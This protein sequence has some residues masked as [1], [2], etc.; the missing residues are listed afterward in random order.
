MGSGQGC[1]H[2]TSRGVWLAQVGH[3]G[4]ETRASLDLY[5]N[6][7]YASHMSTLPRLKSQSYFPSA[8]RETGAS[9]CNYPP[10][11]SKITSP[12]TLNQP[13]LLPGCASKSIQDRQDP[14]E[15]QDMKSFPLSV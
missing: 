15:A 3:E 2:K 14:R 6:Q 7:E 5:L 4:K 10:L 8:A 11:P 13:Y 1:S 9:L 12:L